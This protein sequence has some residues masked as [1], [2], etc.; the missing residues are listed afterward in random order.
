[1]TENRLEQF[2]AERRRLAERFEPQ[3]AQARQELE[4]ATVAFE[5]ARDARDAAT[6]KHRR[7]V[8][9][10]AIESRVIKEA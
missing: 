4:E 1:M 7:L 5:Q 10:Y 6:D 9:R 3:I 8:D 2:R